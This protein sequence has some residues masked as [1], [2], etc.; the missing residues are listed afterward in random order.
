[1]TDQ[2][3]NKEQGVRYLK[4]ER[5]VLERFMPGFD[6]KLSSIPLA[7]REAIRTPA[8]AG[9][10]RSVDKTWSYQNNTVDLAQA[11]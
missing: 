11:R 6:Q 8:L 7:E 1:M 4:R 10:K 9:S 2:D 3:T 5:E